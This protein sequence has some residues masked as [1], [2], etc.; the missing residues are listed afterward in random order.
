[1][2]ETGIV[3][4]NFKNT[5]TFVNIL[6]LKKKTLVQFSTGEFNFRNS[7][8]AFY[9]GSVLMTKN[10]FNEAHKDFK[11]LYVET[12][13]TRKKNRKKTLDVIKRFKTKYKFLSIVNKTNQP[14]NGCRLPKKKRR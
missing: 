13:G 6:N 12:K 14:H 2:K 9:F 3:K 11:Y 4:I 10:L 5:N 7:N 1:M 8:K